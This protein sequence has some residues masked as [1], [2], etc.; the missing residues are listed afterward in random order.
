MIDDKLDIFD[1]NLDDKQFYNVIYVVYR[2][3][4]LLHTFFLLDR[5]PIQSTS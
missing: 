2:A 1:I 3:L 4:W 5:T